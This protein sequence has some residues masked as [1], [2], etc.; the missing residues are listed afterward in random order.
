[1][2]VWI[3]VL[4]SSVAAPAVAGEPAMAPLPQ[5]LIADRAAELALARSAAPPSISAKATVMVLTPRGFEVAAPGSNGF[6]CLVERSW[7]GG[8][9]DPEFW[10]PKI[11]SPICFNPPAARSVLPLELKQTSL[12]L[13]RL[14]RAEIL[15]RMKAAVASQELG[16]PE[17]GALSYMMSRSQHVSDV[18]GHWHPH[19]MF[20]LPSAVLDAA[21]GANLP[22]SPILGGQPELS[23]G[24]RMPATIYLV[25]VARW[26]DGSTAPVHPQ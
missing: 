16:L 11:R 15:A 12:A 17:P 2:R 20:Y 7:Q 5:Y 10:N 24:G 23:T 25:P 9:D 14:P 1:M 13:Q 26:S 22:G 6:V 3:A 21:I 18:A 19:L 4:L 8:L